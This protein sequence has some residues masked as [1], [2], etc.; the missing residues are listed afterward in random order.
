[1]NLLVTISEVLFWDPYEQ[2]MSVLNIR[3]ILEAAQ[4]ATPFYPSRKLFQPREK[5][6]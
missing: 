1:L 4:A 2:A 6:W 5:N 3:E